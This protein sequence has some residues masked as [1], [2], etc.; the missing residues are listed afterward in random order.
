MRRLLPLA[1]AATVA[2][3]ASLTAQTNPCGDKGPKLPAAGGWASYHADSS[4]FKMLYIGHES[5][6]DRIEM[7]MTRTGRDGQPR[8]MVMQLVVPGFPYNMSQATEMVMQGEGRPPMKISGQMMQMMTSRMPQQNQGITPEQCAALTV[9]GHESI[10]V[11]A[12]T[13]AT[14]HYRDAKD[15]TDVWVDPSVPFG[16]VKVVGRGHTLVLTDKGTGGKT[17]IV[18]TPQEMGPGMMG[19]PGGRRPGR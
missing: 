9:V 10:T 2:T 1:L 19:P 5:G 8:P 3:A 11:P 6:G 16:A 12:G 15:S 14:T 4:D 13:F 7:A 17:A 18:G